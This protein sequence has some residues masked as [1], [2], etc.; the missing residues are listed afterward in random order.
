MQGIVRFF[1]TENCW[2]V[3]TDPET[4]YEYHVHINDVIDRKY[5]QRNQWVSFD[6]SDRDGRPSAIN[7]IPIEAP[8]EYLRRGRVSQFFSDRHFE[9]ISYERGSIFFHASDVCRIDGVEYLPVEGCIVEFSRRSEGGSHSG[10]ARQY[11]GVA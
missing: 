4:N 10:R 3:I 7:V 1:R 6:V 2:G 9:F 5:L 8:P 11:F